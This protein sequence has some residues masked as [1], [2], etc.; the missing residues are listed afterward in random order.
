MKLCSV[1]LPLL[2][3]FCVSRAAAVGIKR[4]KSKPVLQSHLTAERDTRGRQLQD[5]DDEEV[6]PISFQLKMYWE[7]GYRWQEEIFERKWCIECDDGSCSRGHQLEIKK[8]DGDRNQR[9]V[10]EEVPGSVSMSFSTTP[11]LTVFRVV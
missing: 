7:P 4:I 9:F 10:Y 3:A 2:A 5:D 1:L 11:V 6:E 8:C